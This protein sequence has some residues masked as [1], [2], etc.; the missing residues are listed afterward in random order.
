MLT[1]KQGKRANKVNEASFKAASMPHTTAEWTIYS[2][3][4][5]DDELPPPS[6]LKTAYNALTPAQ[7]LSVLDTSDDESDP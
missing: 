5:S 6:G 3:E 7:F 2:S 4:L 1:P